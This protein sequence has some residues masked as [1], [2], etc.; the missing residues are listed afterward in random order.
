MTGRRRAAGTAALSFAAFTGLAWAIDPSD[1]AAYWS[2]AIFETK[3]L[4][5]NGSAANQALRGMV[6]RL[7][8]SHPHAAPDLVWL[9]L[10]LIVGVGGFAA[11][12]ACWQHGD[13][14]AGIAITGLLG[15]LLSPVAWIH[16]LCWIVIAIGLIL[17]DGRQSRRVLVAALAGALFLTTL[18]TWAEHTQSAAQLVSV[19][20]FIMENSFGLAALALI[21]ALWWA[22]RSASAALSTDAAAGIAEDPQVALAD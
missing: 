19:R 9:P 12:R 5:G 20:G 6:L 18:P 16:H 7:L 8:R 15:A 3:R 21:P 4:G 13:E 17:G 10:V 22:S 1:S 14:V 11:A 2:G